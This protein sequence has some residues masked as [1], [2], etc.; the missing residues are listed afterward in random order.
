MSTA[1]TKL[2][3]YLRRLPGDDILV[4]AF[5]DIG[6]ICRSRIRGDKVAAFLARLQGLPHT[7]TI[8]CRDTFAPRPANAVVPE[9][10]S[11][12]DRRLTELAEWKV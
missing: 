12:H 2:D 8:Y 5:D 6:H 9:A 4:D 3:H 7:R 11:E 1:E 10:G